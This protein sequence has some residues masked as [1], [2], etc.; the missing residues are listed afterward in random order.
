M[1]E[2]NQ[3]FN[4]EITDE[5]YYDLG[6]TNTHPVATYA[7][8][9]E[10]LLATFHKIASTKSGAALLRSIRA[11]GLWIE[12]QPLNRTSCNAHGNVL[13]LAFPGRIVGASIQLEPHVYMSGSKCFDAESMSDPQW[14]RGIFPEEVLFHELVHA[15]RRM[16][17]TDGS[18]PLKGG[19]QRYDFVDEFFA[20]VLTNIYISDVTN[21]HSSGLRADHENGRPLEKELS[22]SYTFYRSS[23]QTLKLMD[24]LINENYLLCTQLAAVKAIFNPLKAY[25]ENYH[26]VKFM[27]QSCLARQ[28]ERT[29]PNMH[30]P[31]PHFT[32]SATEIIGNLLKDDAL[33]LLR[34][35]H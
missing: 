24:K 13:H 19:L 30:I 6:Y 22:G 14:N 28:R 9:K 23:P 8:W 7:Q 21:R 5:K 18:A 27:S 2:F 33:R 32:R 15:Y 34:H 17:Y 26:L 25:F 4:I 20:V 10:A 1:P 35:L 16:Q 11:T 29:V 12:M 31:G 3:E